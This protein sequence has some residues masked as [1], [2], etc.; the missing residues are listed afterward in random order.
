MLGPTAVGKTHAVQALAHQVGAVIYADMACLYRDLTVGVAKPSVAEQQLVP[1]YLINQLALHQNFSAAQFVQQADERCAQ[2]ATEGKT[3]LMT[4]GTLFYIRNFLFGL[5]Q[6]PPASELTRQRVQELVQTEGLAGVRRRLGEVDA[7][8]LQRLA[9]ADSYRLTR[10]L[11]V[12]YESGQPLSSFAMPNTLRDDYDFFIVVLERPRAQL[13][14]RINERVEQM[15][16]AGLP[17]EVAQLRA[18]GLTLAM[19]ASKC[20]GYREFFM[21]EEGSAEEVKE[22]I[23]LNTRHYAKRQM[24]FL[25][26]LPCHERVA[27]DD[28]AQLCAAVQRF[29]EK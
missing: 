27:A 3:P 1:H 29:I 10:A 11:E 19:A 9:P 22:A 17:E 7:V 8:S 24:T 26:A 4:G 28:M 14:E 6:A 16:A 12:Y 2:L 13:Y 15:W 18:K 23:K 20:I 5:S 21:H 25:R